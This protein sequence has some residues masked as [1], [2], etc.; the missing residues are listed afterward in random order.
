MWRQISCLNIIVVLFGST[1]ALQSSSNTKE[2]KPKA[3][4]IEELVVQ[5]PDPKARSQQKK[6]KQ[7]RDH[8]QHAKVKN[9][10]VHV[11][12]GLDGEARFS[13]IPANE[14]TTKAGEYHR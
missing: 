1:A 12:K 11:S 3:R 2:V 13:D 5:H 4:T 7:E 6:E 9:T 10:K 14:M 8:A